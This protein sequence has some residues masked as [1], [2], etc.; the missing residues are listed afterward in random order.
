MGSEFGVGNKD[1]E[2]LDAGYAFA[3][4]AHFGDVYLVGLAY[5][6]WAAA[7]ATFVLGVS[8]SSLSWTNRT[9]LS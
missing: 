1:W 8:W 5:F 3:S 9:I 6:N 2:A 7:S 4:W